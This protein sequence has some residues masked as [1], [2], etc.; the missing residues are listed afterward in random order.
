LV[1]LNG[2]V[3]IVLGGDCLVDDFLWCNFLLEYIGIVVSWKRS[4]S[5]GWFRIQS[6]MGK[7]KFN[8]GIVVAFQ[9][10]VMEGR[11]GLLTMGKHDG[12]G[13]ENLGRS[14]GRIDL[15]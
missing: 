1:A 12:P 11:T 4:C 10:R 5:Y 8:R 3:R 2:I 14:A 6:K 15:N 13:S 7:S 9:R